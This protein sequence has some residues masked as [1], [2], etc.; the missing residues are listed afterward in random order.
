M[1]CHASGEMSDA[2]VAIHPNCLSAQH[3]GVTHSLY[4]HLAWPLQFCFLLLCTWLLY[5]H[6]WKNLYVVAYIS[7]YNTVP[8]SPCRIQMIMSFV[9]T[10]WMCG[11]SRPPPPHSTSSLLPLSPLSPHHPSPMSP[12]L[13]SPSSLPPPPSLQGWMWVQTISEPHLPKTRYESHPL[14]RARF[15]QYHASSASLGT[16]TYQ[17]LNNVHIV[18]Y[19][20]T[21]KSPG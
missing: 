6:V 5:F 20:Y 13:L 21:H 2:A 3:S 18:T 11:L 1:Y 7:M 16:K 10:L 14:Q 19:I 12:H 4:N 8:C 9:Q 15:G 17:I